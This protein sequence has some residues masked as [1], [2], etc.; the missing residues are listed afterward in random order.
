M[1]KPEYLY[2]PH[3]AIRE[4]SVLPGGE[5]LPGL[6]GWSL[7]QVGSG[8]G[9]WLDGPTSTELETGTVLLVA[10]GTPGRLRASQLNGMSLCLFNVIPARLTGLVTLGEHERFKQA[11]ARKELAVQVI[12]PANPIA[13]KMRDLCA[14]RNRGGLLFRLNLLQL[15]AEALGKELDQ[16][17]PSQEGVDAKARLRAFLRETPPDA[18]LEINFNELARMTHCTSRHLSRVFN[19]LV[20]MSFQSK[21][22][23]IRLARARELLATGS[24]KVVEVALESGY[25]SLSLFNLMFTR[26]FGTSP[27]KWRQKYG[28]QGGYQQNNKARRFAVYRK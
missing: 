21:R 18:M 24:S 20:G 4:F 13:T 6:P 15:L 23:E 9:Y 2:E 28:T 17:A 11:A 12:P 26:R 27:G 1:N 25:K 8:A 14:G 22:A 5:W 7:I 16:A 19:D 10:D 3:L